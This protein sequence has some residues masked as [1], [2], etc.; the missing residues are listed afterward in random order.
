MAVGQREKRGLGRTLGL[1]QAAETFD[2]TI[3]TM[4][5]GTRHGAS[6]T[7]EQSETAQTAAMLC[8]Q[9][10]CTFKGAFS[11]SRGTSLCGDQLESSLSDECVHLFGN[12]ER[13]KLLVQ[14]YSAVT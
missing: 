2:G 1:G 5:Q 10:A 11:P 14:C 6:S 8:S 9:V 7:R 4:N 3:W 12:D 13:Y